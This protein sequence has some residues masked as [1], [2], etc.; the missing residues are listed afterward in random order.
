MSSLAAPWESHPETNS[1][2]TPEALTLGAATT[3]IARVE[4]P[5]YLRFRWSVDGGTLRYQVNGDLFLETS[6]GSDL[7]QTNY[8]GAGTHEIHWRFE[9]SAAGGH[10]ELTAIEWEGL[11][12]IILNPA[13]VSVTVGQPLDLIA[14]ARSWSG[15]P[16]TV[17]W[18]HDGTAIPGATSSTLHIAATT[19]DTA[20][21]YHARFQG[22][23]ASLAAETPPVNVHIKPN[24]ADD[25]IEAAIGSPTTGPW[26]RET[27]LFGWQWTGSLLESN[28]YSAVLERAPIEAGQVYEDDH[29]LRI[30]VGTYDASTGSYPVTVSSQPSPGFADL[31]IDRSWLDSPSNGLGTFTFGRNG[32]FN[33]PALGGD[34][35]TFRTRVVATMDGGFP[36]VSIQTV[37]LRHELSFRIQNQGATT[38]RD[39][40]GTVYILPP[41]IPLFGWIYQP[42]VLQD[43]ALLSIPVSAGDLEAGE[44]AVVTVPYNPSGRFQA[45]LLL[46]ELPNETAL[47]NNVHFESYLFEV[48]TAFGS[49][50]REVEV[51]FSVE[52]GTPSARRISPVIAGLPPGWSG[53]FADPTTGEGTLGSMVPSHGEE[54]F[55]MIVT[56]A[57]P[58]VAKPGEIAEIRAVSLMNLGCTMVPVGEIPMTVVLSHPTR[59]SLTVKDND[60]TAELTGRL[61][62]TTL[63]ADGEPGPLSA[64]ANELV[65]L[66]VTGQD[67]VTLPYLVTTAAD[68][69]FSTIIDTDLSQIRWAKAYYDGSAQGYAPSESSL[70]QWGASPA[71]PI[72]SF[73][74]SGT[75]V[76][77]TAAPGTL[78]GSFSVKGGK[79]PFRFVL[80][81]EPTEPRFIVDGD[82]L[83]TTGDGL[84]FEQN[85][86]L[87]VRVRAE[88]R[89]TGVTFTRTFPID[90]ID[91]Q[92]EDRDGDGLDERDEA[93]AGTSDLHADSD[94]DGFPD[95]QEL[96]LGLD[97][98]LAGEKPEIYWVRIQRHDFADPFAA[99]LSPV[100]FRIYVGRAFNTS[101]DGIYRLDINGNAELIASANLPAGLL[102][103]PEAD[104]IFWSEDRGGVV[105]R[106]A[107]DRG[108]LGLTAG[109]VE[110]WLSDFLPGD[111]DPTGMRLLPEALATELGGS[112][113]SAVLV[114]QGFNGTSGIWRF[115]LDQPDSEV[116][117]F[118]SSGPWSRPVDIEVHDDSL[119][120]VDEEAT[121]MAQ[122]L[123][124]LTEAGERIPIPIYRPEGEVRSAATDPLT[125]ELLVM[126]ADSNSS[127]IYR[128]DGYSGEQ[129]LEL[130]GFSN[131]PGRGSLAF[132]EAGNLLVVT[133]YGGDE[134]HLYAR[135]V[136][137]PMEITRVD[138]D[139]A[140]P[141]EDV[142][143]HGHGFVQVEE[144]LLNGVAQPYAVIDQ[145]TLRV[146]IG[147][148]AETGRILVR[149]L[150]GEAISS[151][152][153]I[154]PTPPSNLRLSTDGVPLGQQP[155]GFVAQI[156]ANDS[157]PGDNL[158]FELLSTDT[159][160]DN[161]FYR[162]NGNWLEV[163]QAFAAEG[164]YLH[165]IA[166]AAVDSYGLRV[167]ETF[168]LTLQTPPLVVVEPGDMTT[169]AG[170]TLTLDVSA[171][172]TPPLAYQWNF[173]GQTMPSELSRQLT[174]VSV[175]DA[176]TGF[177]QVEVSNAFG[178]DQSTPAV[179]SIRSI[180]E[181]V[182]A[183]S[184][185][186]DSPGQMTMQ[187]TVTRTDGARVELERS[188]DLKEWTPV[189]TRL[190]QE[191]VHDWTFSFD[192]S[193]NTLFFRLDLAPEN[194]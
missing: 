194:P 111:D 169:T 32:P 26:E 35:I 69:S 154:I 193:E 157:D 114:D 48:Y 20:G 148:N 155:G 57:D 141:G 123:V 186:L 133:D 61:R 131:N 120:V 94:G 135:I 64:L 110:T 51:D 176:D 139:F 25:A 87:E 174:I 27:T 92:N 2:A 179:L 47:D 152:Y 161:R 188:D 119:L 106:V 18:Y 138:S 53:G 24:P 101:E 85:P 153:V 82:D 67:G 149:G 36:N 81:D 86:S 12:E 8:L 1:L 56:P 130:E 170:S 116:R 34:P 19:A 74:F 45:V 108:P 22:S 180:S 66:E 15:A 187:V 29:G 172:G 77:E 89:E 65:T 38:A 184:F 37:S 44:A 183:S 132:N 68:G 125:G 126:I 167:E 63:S 17:Q 41:L 122:R 163:D 9:K 128:L 146:T 147:A 112:S 124:R 150:T 4:G 136:S 168:L 59:L 109:P 185:S 151:T 95:G 52:N 181:L 158:T 118:S 107:L 30:E 115:D 90:V 71:S 79:G 16:L 145:E 13:P 189:E 76:S 50:Y 103:D 97:P 160:P 78:V 88:D 91:N 117:L 191:G 113:R 164:D 31:V 129:E 10:A 102:I 166:I 156:E 7:P 144:V 175:S 49:P 80:L 58:S 11:P 23:L 99:R 142:I 127:A 162:I 98:A 143:V 33:D 171:I 93:D 137:R 182:E 104:A 43:H 54:S 84:D 3:A 83:R 100:D 39:V 140:S 96:G 173:N 75:F 6:S 178:E 177:Y 105:Y 192:T 134:I 62:Y 73:T 55:R 165:E 60:K 21:E 42:A 28:V 14:D 40:Q 190:L 46:D 159:Y 121:Q 70:E 5:G 72:E